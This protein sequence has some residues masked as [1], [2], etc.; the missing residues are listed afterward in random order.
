MFLKSKG[1]VKLKDT[2]RIERKLLIRTF[3]DFPK[4]YDNLIMDKS[5]HLILTKIFGNKMNVLKR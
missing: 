5:A 1:K 2:K 3:N 4:Y